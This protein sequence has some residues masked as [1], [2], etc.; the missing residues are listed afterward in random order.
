MIAENGDRSDSVNREANDNLNK[1]ANS[2]IGR[3]HQ[4]SIRTVFPGELLAENL[5]DIKGGKTA[6]CKRG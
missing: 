2:F 3:C 1:I 6:V 5:G 4:A